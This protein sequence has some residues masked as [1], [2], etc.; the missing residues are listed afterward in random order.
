MSRHYY[1]CGVC[2]GTKVSKRKEDLVCQ[3]DDTHSHSFH[4][5]TNLGKGKRGRKRQ[6]ELVEGYASRIHRGE[7][8]DE[9]E[10]EED[11][12]IVPG[13]I[14]GQENGQE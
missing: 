4:P 7:I 14:G 12:A 2:G 5:L 9:E 10:D 11:I 13:G 3:G 8:E 1:F 6:Q